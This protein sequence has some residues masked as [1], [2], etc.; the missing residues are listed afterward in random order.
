MLGLLA[1]IVYFGEFGIIGGCMSTVTWWVRL[2]GY[3]QTG[4]SM[5]GCGGLEG[6]ER[7]GK[8]RI[9]K[10]NTRFFF[11]FFPPSYDKLLYSI[12]FYIGGGEWII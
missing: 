12:L 3:A 8:W 9:I 1:V 4:L 10:D 6:R 2:D 11:L 7:E 5:G